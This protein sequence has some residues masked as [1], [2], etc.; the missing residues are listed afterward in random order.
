MKIELLRKKNIINFS[1]SLLLLSAFVASVIYSSYKNQDLSRKI[2][3]L[4]SETSQIISQTQELQSKTMELKRYKTLWPT[5]TENKKNTAGIKMDDVNAKLAAMAEKYTIINPAIKVS[6]P[7]NLSGGL[8]ERSRIN[9]LFTTINLNFEAVDD[10]RALGFLADFSASLPGYAVL[11]RMD[12]VRSKEYTNQDLVQISVG[13]GG[14][15]IKS[16]VD[17]SWYAFKEKEKSQETL[18]N[19][20]DK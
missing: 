15:A 16:S 5:L 20:G 9:V 19:K 17:I 4:K 13:K 18:V 12:I 10:A 11:N 6:L 2:E 3:D 1:S 8:F 14:G 7:E